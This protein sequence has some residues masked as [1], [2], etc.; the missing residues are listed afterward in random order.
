[1]SSDRHPGLQGG[2]APRLAALWRQPGVRTAAPFL[3][4][5]GAISVVALQAD[6]PVLR[7]IVHDL[8]GVAAGGAIIAGVRWHRPRPRR[9]WLLFAAG[10][11]SFAAGTI[12]YNAQALIGRLPVLSGGDV[13]YFAAAPMM[14]LGLVGFAT[15]RT[16]TLRSA[17]V[18]VVDSL[19]LFVAA[20][21]LLWF[22]RL[23]AQVAYIGVPGV[24]RALTVATPTLDVAMLA[25]LTRLVLTVGF[26][27]TATRLVTLGVLAGFGGDLLWH[28]P[29]TV[30]VTTLR[31]ASYLAMFAFVGAAALHPSMRE[32]GELRTVEEAGFR[33]RRLVMLLTAAAV[34]PVVVFT[35]GAALA[36][37]ANTII[38]GVAVAIIPLLVIQRITA[39]TAAAQRVVLDRVRAHE[40]ALREGERLEQRLHHQ[41]FHDALT[42]LPNRALFRDRLAQALR[43]AQHT[44]EGIVV[45]VIDLDDFKSIN[46]SLG[47]ASGDR[48]LIEVARRLRMLL[49]EVDTSARLGDDEFAILHEDADCAEAGER[50]AERVLGALGKPALLEGRAVP[51]ATSVGVVHVAAGDCDADAIL[52]D[53]DVAMYAA[54]AAGKGRH[55]LFEPSMREAVRERMELKSDLLRIAVGDRQLEVCYQ[56][57]VDLR[58]RAIFGFEALL[59][60]HHPTRGMVDT[61]KLIAI[62]EE[63]GAIVPIGRWVLD[64]ACREA[65][66]WLD[67]YEMSLPVAVNVSARQ[68][69]SPELLAD[70]QAALHAS[71]LPARCLV[72][73]ITETEVMQEIDHAIEVLRALKALGVRVA[74]DDFGSGYSSFSQ[75]ERLPVDMIK[76]DRDFASSQRQAR[77]PTLVERSTHATLIESVLDIARKLE[78]ITVVEGIETA[79]QLQELE[80]LGCPLGQGYLFSR[81]EPAVAL[82]ALIAAWPPIDAQPVSAREVSRSGP[83]AWRRAGPPR[84]ARPRSTRR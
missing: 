52:R 42:G 48:L 1:M 31:M 57:I 18:L 25:L 78:L 32:L 38:F 63:T 5:S 80:Q 73:E 22:F 41:A 67:R 60:W 50:L 37:R 72:L 27:L 34:P 84:R 11:L 17:Q 51:L 21:T 19:A 40:R 77:V 9:W 44:G 61:S 82:D 29:P 30:G 69:D 15:G 33:L 26:R 7:A 83:S 56:P 4:A 23:D 64:Q 10:V 46:D 6:T 39:V 2:L 35:H 3:A 24:V 53:A 81:A 68:L 58:T 13:L 59:R 75:L 8:V 79:E 62:A 76:V 70:V 66:R 43:R 71:R 65:R 36:Q 54:K 16:R 20:F 55:T 12:V 14:A 45:L 74:I 49:R 28:G 47:P